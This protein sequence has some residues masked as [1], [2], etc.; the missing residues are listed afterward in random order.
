LT[1]PSS[2]HNTSFSSDGRQAYGYLALPPSGQGPG[3]I[4]IQEWWGLDDHIADL[5]DRLAAEG[6]VAFAPDLYG[7]RIA[8]EADD[9]LRMMLELPVEEGARRLSGAV[10][11]LLAHPAVTSG[12]VGTIGFCMG[13]GFVL[14]LAAQEG[15]R[16]AAA[17]PFYGVVQGELPDFSGLRAAVQGH[18][19]KDDSTTPQE[20]IAPLAEAIEKGS[21]Q[22]PEI[23][24]YPA[25]HAFLNDQRPS[26]EP[27]SAKLAWR[28][29]V[30]F[31][32]DHLA[33][34]A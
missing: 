33:P 6:F 16:I 2:R 27:D 20:S 11:H 24:L 14:V 18:Y 9:A 25:G 23:H 12:K 26:Y 15:D 8:H 17:V 19:G 4:V 3:V 29:A 7:G 32:R 31:L 1:E 22:A 13:G 30:D 21:G 34:T 5:T 10:D 28:R